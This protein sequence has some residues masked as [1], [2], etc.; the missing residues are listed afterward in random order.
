MSRYSRNKKALRQIEGRHS[1][2]ETLLSNKK[3]SYI[4]ISESN[5]VGPQIEKIVSMANEKKIK[6]NFISKKNIENALMNNPELIKIENTLEKLS[7]YKDTKQP[8]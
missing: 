6:V 8:Y 5:E 1:V 2:I 4:D 7:A 3:V